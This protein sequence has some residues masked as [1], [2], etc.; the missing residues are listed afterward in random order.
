MLLVVLSSYVLLRGLSAI[1]TGRTG[2]S[3]SQ[4]DNWLAVVGFAVLLMV[5]IVKASGKV[6]SWPRRTKAKMP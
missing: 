4:V 6:L 3:G 5:G 2:V 1:R